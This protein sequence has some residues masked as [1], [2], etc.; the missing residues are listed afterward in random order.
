MGAIGRI[1]F[2][3]REE[4][5]RSLR[6]RL[7]HS[8]PYLPDSSVPPISVSTGTAKP[9]PVGRVYF[10]SPTGALHGGLVEGGTRPTAIDPPPVSRRTPSRRSQNLSYIRPSCQTPPSSRTCP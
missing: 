2:F 4:I 3:P 6:A 5:P 9:P 1:C 10:L 7:P 8:T